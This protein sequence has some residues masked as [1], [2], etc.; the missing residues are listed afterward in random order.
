M[1]IAIIAC[2]AAVALA[3]PQFN[4]RSRQ[5]QQQGR[6][7]QQPPTSQRVTQRPIAILRDDRQDNGN[8]EFR[9]SFESENGISETRTGYRGS[10]G[11]TNM[12]GS[13]RFPLPDGT[14]AEVRYV[15]D[16]NGFRAESPLIPTPHPLPAHAIEQIR[17]AEEQRARGVTWP[18]Y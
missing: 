5:L 6:P 12:E 4:S 2:L 14:F 9:Y 18:D 1:K 8:G 17:F 11:Q 13:Y 10:Q 3:S 16:E 7:F 15:A